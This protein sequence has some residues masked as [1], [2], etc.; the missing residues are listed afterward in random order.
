MQKLIRGFSTAMK[1]PKMELT[2]RTPY[3]TLFNKYTDFRSITTKTSDAHIVIMNKMPPALHMLV[4]GLISIKPE[5]DNKSFVGEFAHFGGWMVIQADNT[6]EIY[7]LDAVERPAFTPAK[8]DNLVSL[9]N[10][11]GFCVKWLESIR[12]DAEKTFLKGL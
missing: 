10:E 1:K 2:I 12:G 6:C 3:K 8:N 7:L 5:T 9:A 4:P 11:E